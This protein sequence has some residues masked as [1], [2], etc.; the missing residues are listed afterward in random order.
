M[1]SW[2]PAEENI[3]AQIAEIETMHDP[4]AQ[5]SDRRIQCS[6]IEA[7]RRMRRR[8]RDGRYRAPA[9]TVLASAT[10]T[11]RKLTSE[12]IA[13]LR[14]GRAKLIMSRVEQNAA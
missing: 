6:R 12:H 10:E 9:A 3:I 14:A 13:A 5:A 11:S 8:T 1:N 4:L 2:T 7:L